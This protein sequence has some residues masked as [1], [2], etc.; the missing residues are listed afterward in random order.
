M[1]GTAR[2]DMRLRLSIVARGPSFMTKGFSRT[3]QFEKLK[4]GKLGLSMNEGD[5]SEA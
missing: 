3:S 2:R 4:R 5:G 1:P